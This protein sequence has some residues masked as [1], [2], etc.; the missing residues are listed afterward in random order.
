MNIYISD[1]YDYDHLNYHVDE[2]FNVGNAMRFSKVCS[3]DWYYPGPQNT[4]DDG[5][6][7]VH[8]DDF[9]WYYCA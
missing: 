3:G 1:S 9:A 6:P 7:Y 8:C 5:T 2:D 4:Y